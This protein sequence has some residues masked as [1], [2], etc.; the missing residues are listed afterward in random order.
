MAEKFPRNH[1]PVVSQRVSGQP[2]VPFQS[3]TADTSWFGIN[4]SDQFPDLGISRSNQTFLG[5]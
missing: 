1:V 2:D 4:Q 3:L 5:H